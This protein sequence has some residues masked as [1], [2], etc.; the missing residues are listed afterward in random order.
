MTRYYQ[1]SFLVGGNGSESEDEE[2][3]TVLEQPTEPPSPPGP[4]NCPET[5]D[6]PA[7]PNPLEPPPDPKCRRTSKPI[8]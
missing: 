3:S 1:Y 4:P 6:P 8:V 7:P 2:H 5:W